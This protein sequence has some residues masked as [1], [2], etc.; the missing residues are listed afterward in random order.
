MSP[1]TGP[2]PPL[3][4]VAQQVAGKTIVL[5]PNQAGLR[6]ISLDFPAEAEAAVTLSFTDGNQVAWP[7]GLDN[8]YRFAPFEYGLTMG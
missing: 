7:V 6:A 5:D 4:E 8:V 3:P 1:P 2:V